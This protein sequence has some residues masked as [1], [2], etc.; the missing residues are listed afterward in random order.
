MANRPE[1]VIG[2]VGA[3]GTDLDQVSDLIKSTLREFDY[4]TITIRLSQLLM[5]FPDPAPFQKPGEDLA[6]EDRLFQA[7]EA[8]N[9]LRRAMQNG[10]ALAILSIIRIREE[11]A[12]RSEANDERR[13]DDQ[14]KNHA[15]LLRSLKHPDE[16]ELLRD[17]YG[18]SFFLISAYTPK[19]RR[20]ELLSQRIARSHNRHRSD[21]MEAK[22]LELMEK[23]EEEV[24]DKFGQQVRKTFWKADAYV[25]TTNQ[26]VL[27]KSIKR[28][29]QIFFGH[30]FQ[31]PTRDEYLMFSAQAAAYRSASMGR[32]VGAVIATPDGSIL[33]TGTNEVPKAG[34][35]QYWSDDPEDHRDHIHGH[36]SSDTM[37]QEL[38]GD[39]LERLGQIQWLVPEKRGN[40]HELVED[41]LYGADPIMKAAEFNALTE[42]QRPVH[43][44]M[45]AIIDAAR[46]GI[47]IHGATVFTTTFPC[48]GCARHIVA[49]GI[50]RVVYIEPYAKSL[51]R[52]L[53]F[54]SISIEEPC[55]EGN[56]VRFQPFVGLAPRR[57]LD[58]FE[59]GDRKDKRGKTVSWN[60]MQ[61][62]PRIGG[63]NFILSR[64]NEDDVMYLFEQFDQL[65]RRIETEGDDQ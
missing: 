50:Q 15:F 4:Q 2:L 55:T 18:P 14:L 21:G 59:M 36:D 13:G 7:M 28:I 23:D 30:P 12:K 58:C 34:G 11:R 19:Q 10:N 54:D 52:V 64:A 47:S 1:I 62:H 9:G 29:F 49:A 51:A 16:V 17:V 65:Q 24:E 39:I 26:A 25:D 37:R 20:L 5:D 57:Y 40:I 60:P 43:A 45:S 6:E 44:E 41:L 63:W 27:E 8:G 61:A 53:H 42:Y 22:A 46:R 31:T 32:Q 3:L 38:L 56:K 33:A 48:H 35:G